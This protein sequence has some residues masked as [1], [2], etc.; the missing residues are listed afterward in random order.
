MIGKFKMNYIIK[1]SDI[2]EET[3]YYIPDD[4]TYLFHCLSTDIDN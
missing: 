2:F 1:N 4:V 3:K